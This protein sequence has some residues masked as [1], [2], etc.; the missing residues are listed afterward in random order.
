MVSRGFP[1][2]LPL[3]VPSP[4]D[5]LSPIVFQASASGS[6]QPESYQRHCRLLSPVISH[7]IPS[8]CWW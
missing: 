1:G 8:Q 3:V 4:K 6:S 2:A 7:C 5:T